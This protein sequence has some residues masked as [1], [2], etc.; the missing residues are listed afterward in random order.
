LKKY[1]DTGKVRLVVHDFPLNIHANAVPAAEA[2][3]CA[4]DQGK[5]WPMHDG[6]FAEP[7]RQMAAVPFCILQSLNW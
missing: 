5:F 6:L 7:G 3:H 1:V 2:A 4:G